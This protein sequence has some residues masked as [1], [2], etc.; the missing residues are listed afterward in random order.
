MEYRLTLKQFQE[1][2]MFDSKG[3]LH[4]KQAIRLKLFPYVSQNNPVEDFERLVGTFLCRIEDKKPK[5]ISVSE[6]VERLKEDTDIGVG[7]EQLFYETVKQIFFDSA[8]QIRALNLQLLMQNRCKEICEEKLAE[9][10]VDVLGDKV[11]L[12]NV[13]QNALQ[14]SEKDSNVFE[15]LAV[16]KLEYIPENNSSSNHYFRVVDSLAE[17]FSKDFAFVLDSQTRTREYLVSLLEFYCFTYT[18][19]VCMQLNRLTEGERSKNVPLYFCLEWE[20]TS[21]SRLCYSQGWQQLQKAMEKMFAHAVV[22]EILNQTEPGSAQV[23]YIELAQLVKDN[24]NLDAEVAAMIDQVT[25]CYRA[26]ITDCPE[27]SELE[28]RQVQEDKTEESIKYLFD[29][30][31]TQFECA[32]LPPYRRYADNFAV[33]CQKYLK[34]RGR[35]GQMLNITEENLIFL[36]KLAIKNQ[37]QMRLIDVF[38]EFQARGVFLDDFSK[39]QVT[40]YYEKL[41]L[42]EKK[43]DSGDAKYVR[44]IL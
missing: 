8:E 30:V 44:R 10:L 12:N 42:I 20:K 9:Y 33:L 41:N 22:L 3:K 4:H 16:S 7:K 19:Q 35:S 39:E 6:L 23:D 31:K 43:S 1:G 25:E 40:I 17:L 37:E 27:M 38:D 21:Q 14:K 15:R 5:G 13:L 2:P 36:T 34:R 29:S 11:N 26:A 32:R 28:K 18:A 24:P